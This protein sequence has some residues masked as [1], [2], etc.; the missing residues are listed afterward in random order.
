MGPRV[1]ITAAQRG[2]TSALLRA[3]DLQL[4][5]RGGRLRARVH[6]TA[7]IDGPIELRLVGV[8]EGPWELALELGPGAWLGKGLG[9]ELAR[10]RSTLRLRDHAQ[11]C[12]GVRFWLDTGEI[13][14]GP[15]VKVR[16]QTAL[17]VAGR[18]DVG[19]LALIGF[20]CQVHCHGHIELHH[21]SGLGHG[22]TVVDTHHDVDGSD[23]WWAHQP[24]AVEPVVVGSNAGVMAGARV[25]H[26][27][28]LGR[29]CVVGANSVVRSGEY[30][31]GSVLVGAPARVVKKLSPA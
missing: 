13:D 30:P 18:L 5:L 26:G 2:R 7:R 20:G 8:G 27:V 24:L 10:G 16:E 25:L 3:L 14:L 28:R 22:V 19:E 12:S 11:V 4:R 29:N 17:H 21:R 6:R 1:A 31:A 15:R 23:E 9:I